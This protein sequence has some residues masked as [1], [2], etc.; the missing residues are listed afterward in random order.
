[1]S[2]KEDTDINKKFE[3]ILFVEE[4]AQHTGYEEGF[5]EGIVAKNQWIDGFHF[6]FHRASFLGAQ[7][8]Y[9]CGTLEQY[10]SSNKCNSEKAISI[11]KELLQQINNFPKCNDTTIEIAKTIDDIKFKYAKFCSL[12]KI[13]SLY[14]EADKLDF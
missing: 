10:L 14:P 1:M 3:E 6:G 11:A 9:Y 7:L 5:E 4:N 2:N 12:T 8:G 13:C